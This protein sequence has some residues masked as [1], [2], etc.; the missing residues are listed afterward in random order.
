MS[1]QFIQPPPCPPC[2]P[3]LP[4]DIHPAKRQP[5]S[6]E[7][8][9]VVLFAN[10]FSSEAMAKERHRIPLEQVESPVDAVEY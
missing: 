10:R 6:P 1:L 2:E 3:F 8:K 7:S 4:L 5:H 9:R